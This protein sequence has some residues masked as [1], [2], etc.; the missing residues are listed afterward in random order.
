MDRFFEICSRYTLDQYWQE[1]LLSM[2]KGK[3]PKEVTKKDSCTVTVNQIDISCDDP[4]IFIPMFLKNMRAVGHTSP[5]E[6]ALPSDVETEKVK[7]ERK[8]PATWKKIKSK[9]TRNEQLVDYV[10][11]IGEMYKLDAKEK[12]QLYS[13]IQL[14]F[15]FHQISSDDVISEDGSITSVEGLVFD[16]KTRLFS[17]PDK[18]RKPTCDDEKKKPDKLNSLIESYLKDTKKLL[19]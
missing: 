3:Y 16:D 14:A 10:I 17:F 9:A 2:S 4:K 18:K 13:S 8:V 19:D 12:R 1:V 11:R 15:F 7:E 5:D 6:N